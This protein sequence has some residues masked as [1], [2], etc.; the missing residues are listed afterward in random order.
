[1]AHHALTRERS[2]LERCLIVCA[3]ATLLEHRLF[4]LLR[5][6]SAYSVLCDS[7]PQLRKSDHMQL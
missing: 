2:Q 3:I 1:M 4:A 6:L 5:Y 7:L